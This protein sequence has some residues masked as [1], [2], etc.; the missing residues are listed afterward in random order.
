[1]FNFYNPKKIMIFFTLDNFA[2]LHL[3]FGYAYDCFSFFPDQHEQIFLLDHNNL[4][5]I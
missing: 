1:M 4:E 3:K 5:N 2:W